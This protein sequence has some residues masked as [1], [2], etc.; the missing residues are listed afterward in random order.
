MDRATFATLLAAGAAGIPLSAFAR[1]LEGTTTTQRTLFAALPR[2]GTGEWTRIILGSG[3]AY[4]KQIGAGAERDRNGNRLLF[5][6]TQIGSPG[7]SCNPSSMRKAYLRQPRFGSLLDAYPLVANIGRTENFIY[8]FGD[9]RDGKPTADDTLRLL[10]EAYLY[11]VR[12]VRIISVS[13]QT[14]HAASRNVPA[15]HVAAEFPALGTGTKQRMRQVQLWHH[16]EFP[17]GV[18][19]YSA[20]LAGLEPFDAHVYAYG[21]R[22]KSL[23]DISLAR[24]R[25][26]TP[27]GQ[28]GQL[29]QGI[30]AGNG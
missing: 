14:I 13:E 6:E 2:I 4:Q 25:A 28:Y 23:L 21:G 19:R 24:A 11:D 10:D 5:I 20:T 29:P 7:G 9:V 17:F 8:R 1:R 16:P 18:V 12:P 15:T 22:F 27:D 26:M 30:G 3:V